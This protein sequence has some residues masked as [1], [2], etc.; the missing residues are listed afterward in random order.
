MARQST[1]MSWE[2][3]RL[4]TKSGKRKAARGVR[5]GLETVLAASNAI[6]PLDEGPLQRSGKVDVDEERLEG[7]VSYDTPYAVIQHENLDYKHAPG[8]QA[9]Y[10]ET[11]LNQNRNAVRDAVARELRSWLRGR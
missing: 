11:A 7:T 5:Q 1:S 3:R 8:R 6:V 10:L 4:W 9:K 2:G